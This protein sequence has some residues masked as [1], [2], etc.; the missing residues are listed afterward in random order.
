MCALDRAATSLF[1]SSGG[2]Q[3]ANIKFFRG[4]RRGVTAEELAEQFNRAEAQ[5]RAGLSTPCA[6]I[7][8]D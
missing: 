3:V 2:S 5:V 6:N 4:R 1:P 8:D 7:D